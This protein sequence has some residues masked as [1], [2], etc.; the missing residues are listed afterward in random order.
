MSISAIPV[1]GSYRIGIDVG[2]KSVGLA[3][4]AYD[5]DGNVDSILACVSH[6][7]D[8]GAD[9]QH[10]KSPVSRKSSSGTARRSMRLNRARRKRLRKLDEL[11]CDI[12]IPD[13]AAGNGETYEAWRARDIL[14]RQYIEDDALRELLLGRAVRHIARHRGWRNPWQ[15]F[16]TFLSIENSGRSEGLQKIFEHAQRDFGIDTSEILTLGQLVAELLRQSAKNPMKVKIRP[17]TTI[18]SQRQI[19]PNDPLLS[20]QIRQED[21]LFELRL[22]LT[23]QRVAEE[24]SEQIC[25]LVFTQQF[26][27]VPVERIGKDPLPGMEG[28]VRAPRA[29]LDTIEDSLGDRNTLP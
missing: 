28:E 1:G 10:A 3:A 27:H 5:R 17:T 24:L 23:T 2:E 26:P 25:K 22:I 9:P 7:H 19:N 18:S 29:S 16:E 13:S 12:G 14:S 20:T 11:L 6:I 4:L 15:R 21:S 8:G